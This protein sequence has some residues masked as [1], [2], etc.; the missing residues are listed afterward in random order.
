MESF[1][2][3]AGV[4]SEA[5]TQSGRDR[6]ELGEVARRAAAPPA[7]L[8]SDSSSSSSVALTGRQTASAR[9]ASVATRNADQDS[10]ARHG[11]AS[12]EWCESGD[13]DARNSES[14]RDHS[15]G[16]GIRPLPTAGRARKPS[17]A[18][19]T[20]GIVLDSDQIT[21]LVETDQVA[22]PREDRHVGDR[23]DLAHDPGARRRA[24]RRAPR[25]GVC[26][27]AT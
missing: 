6:V 7:W 17:S 14:P 11:G 21:G 19:M 4:R 27:S 12:R 9:I 20:S 16:N 26:D 3:P 23:V 2:V 18:R 25:A 13:S 10:A 24:A 22:H 15:R 5:V 1:Q 8:F